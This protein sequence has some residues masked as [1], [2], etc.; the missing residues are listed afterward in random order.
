MDLEIYKKVKNELENN[1]FN[2]T[3]SDLKRP[4]GAFFYID[5]N[6]SQKFANTFFN[7]LN[8]E[9]LKI[10]G[11]LSPKLLVI[12]PNSRLSWQYH[13]RRSEIWQVYKEKIG[14]IVSNDDNEKEM[15]V[16]NPGDQIKIKKGVR[17]RIIGLEKHALVA[18]IWQH[19]EKLP[20]DEY[21]IVRIKDDFG[22]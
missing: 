12:K 13:K 6:Q 18:E 3:I 20:S 16:L 5:E 22:R 19:T 4:W 2:L 15:K 21:D 7:K 14:V 10:N 8:V 9:C 17:H 1:G 11:K